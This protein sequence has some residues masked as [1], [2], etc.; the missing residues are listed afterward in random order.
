ML[1]SL[2]KSYDV[3]PLFTTRGDVTMLPGDKRNKA[4]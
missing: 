1:N 2:P 3:R 4:S